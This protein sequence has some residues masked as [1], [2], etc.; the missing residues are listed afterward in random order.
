MWPP[1]AGVPM[2]PPPLV[3]AP[4]PVVPALLA[5]PGPVV[6]V[7]GGLPMAYPLAGA[8]PHDALAA[9]AGALFD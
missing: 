1:V 4:V 3:V 6:P 7:A 9:V 5:V 2:P 8:P